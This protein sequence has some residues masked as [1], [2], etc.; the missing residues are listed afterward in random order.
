MLSFLI[1]T[2]IKMPLADQV[3][4]PALS[5]SVSYHCEIFTRLLCLSYIKDYNRF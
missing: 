2:V 4:Y 1:M 3:Y 5:K